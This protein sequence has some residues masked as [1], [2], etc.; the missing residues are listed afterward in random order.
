MQ[1]ETPLT[2]LI[3]TQVLHIDPIDPAAE[4]IQAAAAIINAGRLVAFPT[5]TV[6]GLG[7]DAL[8]GD[9]IERIYVAKQRPA[10]DPIIAHIAHI[11]QLAQLVVNVPQAGYDLADALWPG[12][13]TIVLRRGASVPANIATGLNTVAVRMP[14]NPVAQALIQAADTAIAAPSANTFT[15]PSATT[16]AHVLHD[17]GGR[18]DM[19]L[20]GGPTNIGLESTVVDLTGDVPLVLRPGGVI[21]DDLR[22]IMPAVKSRVQF[23]A[24][25]ATTAPGQM[26]KHYSPSALLVLYTGP[27]YSVLLAMREAAAQYAADGKRVGLL[28]AQEDIHH[29]QNTGMVC[30]LGH[31]ADL[32]TIS[33]NLFAKMR[34]LDKR[35]ID[36]ILARDFGRAGLGAA[37][38]DRLLRAAEGKVI[39]VR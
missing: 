31:R 29:L 15:R 30:N 8:N 25:E 37:L 19:V 26:L 27:L 18:I 2:A 21:M 28:V 1:E 24:D 3:Q 10:N 16:A 9:A 35:D 13:L 11:D 7:A 12:P 38:W 39:Q 33:H 32:K 5:E 20:D 34:E 4:Q 14:S 17:L 23:T 22:R 36:V 6:Y